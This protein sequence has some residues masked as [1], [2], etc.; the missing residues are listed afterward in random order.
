MIGPR[1]VG[2]ALVLV[3]TALIGC[4]DKPTAGATLDSPDA[5][6]AGTEA[7]AQRARSDRTS[8]AGGATP[9]RSLV[10]VAS[11]SVGEAEP[12]ERTCGR[13]G[14]CLLDGDEVN[15]FE[16]GRLE[17]ACLETCVHTPESQVRAAFLGCEAKP[18]CDELLGCAR[19]NWEPLSA[20]HQGPAVQGFATRPADPCVNGCRWY[21]YCAFANAPPGEGYLAPEYDVQMLDCEAN[22]ESGAFDSRLWLRF[23]ECAPTKCSSMD[24]SNC[25]DFY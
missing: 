16:A 7:R 19:S 5:A 15:A 17:L 12:C 8:L 20:T 3:G 21:F 24:I 2:L 18:G 14:D 9:V 11:T 10:A 1:V 23:N 13:V 25:F 22:C 6:A 4:N